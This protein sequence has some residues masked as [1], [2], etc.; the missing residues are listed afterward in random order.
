MG[1]ST[2]SS[3]ATV[4]TADVDD[5]RRAWL[6]AGQDLLRRG[7]FQ[8]VKL[9]P[10]CDLTGRTT[11]SF[12]HHFGSMAGYL[13]ELAAYFGG[14]QPRSVLDTIRNLSPERRLRRLQALG[15]QL[16]MG[17]LHLAMRDWAT[18]SGLAAVAVREADLVLLEFIRDCLT[19]AGLDV[20]DA[21]LRAE[22]LYA[23]GVARFD[24]PWRRR[25]TSVDRLLVEWGGPAPQAAQA[26]EAGA[27]S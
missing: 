6:D 13:G 11:G 12:Y 15:L 21:E 17:S 16:H 27:G 22:V 10:L 7:G 14:E 25:S 5:S 19:D 2:L 24:T 20:V 18:V 9:A 4:S 23:L 8:S 1:S 3:G 26:P